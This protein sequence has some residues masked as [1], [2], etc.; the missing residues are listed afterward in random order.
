MKQS[1]TRRVFLLSPVELMRMKLN[2]IRT[3]YIEMK[4]F[5]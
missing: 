3:L 2:S 4:L 5:W 1:L